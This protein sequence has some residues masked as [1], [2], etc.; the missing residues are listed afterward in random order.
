M[1]GDVPN[2]GQGGGSG[3]GRTA[4]RVH[5]D[6]FTAGRRAVGEPDPR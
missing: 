6:G 3:S 2:D 4:D 1:G 5:G